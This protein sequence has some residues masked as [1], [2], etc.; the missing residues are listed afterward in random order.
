MKRFKSLQL[1]LL[2]L[3]Q[4]NY[5]TLKNTERIDSLLKNFE[6]SVREMKRFLQERGYSR[7]HFF[8]PSDSE[9]SQNL[10]EKSEN[11]KETILNR[12]DELCE[13]EFTKSILNL[14]L[15]YRWKEAEILF[16]RAKLRF[17]Q[18]TDI[19]SAMIYTYGKVGLYT[20]A[21][22]VFEEVVAKPSSQLNLKMFEA[23]LEAYSVHVE[24]Q[25][26]AA[27]S[28]DERS[29]ETGDSIYRQA[30]LERILSEISMDPAIKIYNQILELKFSPTISTITRI[31]RLAGR[32]RRFS[33]VED[34]QRECERLNLKFDPQALEVLIFAQMQCGRLEQAEETLYRTKDILERLPEEDLRRILNV[35]LFGYCRFRRPLEAKRLLDTFKIEPSPSALSFLVGTAAKCGFIKDAEEFYKKLAVSNSQTTNIL[36]PAANHLLSA[37]LR[38]ADIQKFFELIDQLG[39]ENR[40]KYTNTMLFDALSRSQDLNRLSKEI[41]QVKVYL[42]RTN[43][44]SMELSSLF[45]CLFAHFEGEDLLI[46]DFVKYVQ[47]EIQ[48]RSEESRKELQLI[49]LEV[50]SK[51]REWDRCVEIVRE[52]MKTSL[53]PDP[54]VFAKLMTAAGPNPERIEQVLNWMRRVKCWRDPAILTAAMEF[55]WQAGCSNESRA[56]WEEIKGKRNKARSFSVAIATMSEILLK[57]EGPLSALN[58]LNLYKN[59][60][61]DTA[62][63]VYLKSLRLSASNSTEEISK[64][65]FERATKM[66]PKPSVSVCNEILI[67]CITK[68]EIIEKVADWMSQNGCHPNVQTVNILL[69]TGPGNETTKLLKVA[70]GLLD[71]MIKVGAKPSDELF[72]RI[73]SGLLEG[74]PQNNQVPQAEFYSKVLLERPLTSP[75]TKLQIYSIWLKF[76]DKTGQLDKVQEIQEEIGKL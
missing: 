34:M 23:L 35:M 67:S 62:L 21:L 49:L 75:Q 33:L 38:D 3:P 15:I 29:L 1:S 76:F 11:F 47:G 48:E 52:L 69:A 66:N 55:Y 20:E 60:W 13:W 40:D 71:E 24:R 30:H 7:R 32:L 25:I 37:Y 59:L 43:L 31:I 45:K 50:S 61:N 58:H 42:S 36:V 17:P 64:F 73:I 41:E 72:L 9:I 68:L 16:E 51:Q 28:L 4:K 65:F 39:P 53:I 26:L 5:E 19:F 8:S 10:K 27:N 74:G 12:A 63:R 14:G 46:K 44:S 18:S 70:C 2:K 57:E 54:L 56:L 6:N 22:K